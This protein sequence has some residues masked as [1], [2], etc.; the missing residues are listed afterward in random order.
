MLPSWLKWL[1]GIGDDIP[2]GAHR[3]NPPYLWRGLPIPRIP[4]TPEELLRKI[5]PGVKQ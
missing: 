4:D 3:T 1:L 2:V 5:G